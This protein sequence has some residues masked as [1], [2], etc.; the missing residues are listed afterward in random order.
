MG[1]RIGSRIRSVDDRGL[2]DRT[3]QRQGRKVRPVGCQFLQ[4][5]HMISDKTAELIGFA[6]GQGGRGGWVW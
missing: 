4:S 3:I 2:L 1:S 6:A 5:A